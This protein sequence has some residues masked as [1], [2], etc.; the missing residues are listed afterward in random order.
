MGVNNNKTVVNSN[1]I[2]IVN[3]VAFHPFDHI[4]AFS[5]IGKNPLNDLPLPVCIY[6]FDKTSAMTTMQADQ[7]NAARTTSPKNRTENPDTIRGLKVRMP[8]NAAA[9]NKDD[10]N[11]LLEQY[12]SL[13]S[14]KSISSVERKKMHEE[15]EKQEKPMKKQS[16]RKSSVQERS[17]E[18]LKNMLDK[19]E[20]F[21]QDQGQ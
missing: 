13:T 17:P 16:L 10:T 5:G 2:P 7:E 9:A 15:E 11:S 8:V 18:K 19:L 3:C 4:V 12:S 21:L 6:T 1:N 20:K 14:R